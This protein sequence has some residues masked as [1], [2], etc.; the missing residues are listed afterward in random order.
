MLLLQGFLSC[1]Y[2]TVDLTF[3]FENVREFSKSLVSN[4]IF[5]H[6]YRDFIRHKKQKSLN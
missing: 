5:F 1:K 2:E 6:C 4:V 3:Q